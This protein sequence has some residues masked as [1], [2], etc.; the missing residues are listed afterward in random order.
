MDSKRTFYK[1]F[2][3]LFRQLIPNIGTVLVVAVLLLANNAYAAGLNAGT[4]PSTI[5]YQG[6][7]ATASGTPVNTSVGLTFRLYNVQSGGSAL[8]AEAHTGAN[9]VPVSNGLFNARLGSITPIPSAVWDNPTVYL[10]IQVEGDSSELL[11]REL[12]GAVPYSIR[13]SNTVHLL[14]APIMV[15]NKISTPD[16]TDWI[17][18]NLSQYVPPTAKSVLLDI[19]VAPTGAGARLSIHQ[20]GSQ[21]ES[22]PRVESTAG[23]DFGQGWVNLSGQSIEYQAYG[24]GSNLYYYIQIVGYLE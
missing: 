10:G 8:W 23:W 19:G 2:S 14:D 16:S 4:S 6:T 12:I 1:R 9:A 17:T 22:T 20:L 24:F 13:A 5:S 7:L 3:W 21:S 18:L 11:P 15:V